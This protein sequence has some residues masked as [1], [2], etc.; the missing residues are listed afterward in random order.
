MKKTLLKTALLGASISILFSGCVSVNGEPKVK[1]KTIGTHNLYAKFNHKTKT[2]ESIQNKETT[3][4]ILNN[5]QPIGYDEELYSEPDLVMFRSNAKGPYRQVSCSDDILDSIGL[6]GITLVLTFGFTLLGGGVMCDNIYYFD[7]KK[8]DTDVKNSI[9]DNDRKQ[10]VSVFDNLKKVQL[11][12]E[13]IINYRIKIENAKLQSQYNDF[14]YNYYNN[15]PKLKF[16]IV[17]KSGL[18][19]NEKLPTYVK[20]INN[21]IDKVA[22][23]NNISYNSIVDNAFPCKISEYPEKVKQAQQD[24]QTQFEED[25]VFVKKESNRL[26]IKDKKYLT[27]QVSFYKIKNDKPTTLK[28]FN[29]KTIYYDVK[30][31][32]YIKSDKKVA[33]GKIIVKNADYK[34]VFQNYSNSNKDLSISFNGKTQTYTLTNLTDMFIQIKSISLYY[35]NTIYNLTLNNDNNEYSI[36][37]SPHSIKDISLNRSIKESKYT[38]LTKSKAKKLINSFGFAIKYTKGQQNQN[39]TLY[40]ETKTSVY[41]L[42]KDI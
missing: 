32:N 42:I 8:F 27:K 1:N 9:T 38:N 33:N 29:N 6:T 31:K 21:P 30:I 13:N 18:Y 40:K 11:D 12:K 23:I 39:I 15:Q 7:Y 34:D 17:D 20:I 36:E 26:L 2:I 35:N 28:V 4:F 22:S 37:L 10:I 24:I 5:Y 14:V 3:G 19:H 25:K 41:N 16:S